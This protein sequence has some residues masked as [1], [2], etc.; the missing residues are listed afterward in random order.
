[1]PI[2]WEDDAYASIGRDG[3]QDV[4]NKQ[5]VRDADILVGFF[6]TRL[7]TAT[8]KAESGSVEEINEFIEAGKPVLLY[9]SDQPVRMEGVDQKQYASLV[10]FRASLQPKGLTFG[11]DN[12]HQLR[13]LLSGHLLRTVRERFPGNPA[14]VDPAKGH[15]KLAAKDA[16]EFLIK[17]P[18]LAW[19]TERDSATH[20]DA[21]GKEVLQRLYESLLSWRATYDTAVEDDVL[22]DIDSAIKNTKAML[23]HKMALDGGV[24]WKAFW[25][26]GDAAFSSLERAAKRLSFEKPEDSLSEQA[27][28]LLHEIDSHPES[29]ERGI[30]VVDGRRLGPG[31]GHYFPYQWNSLHHSGGS[32]D[33]GPL[34]P[35]RKCVAELTTKRYLEKASDDGHFAIYARSG[36]PAPSP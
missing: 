4:I 34:A 18:R 13:E 19:V 28:E 6:W 10:T 5:I 15:A 29:E 30:T 11:Y 20:T 2:K 23:Q 12:M 32:V 1:M 33:V 16:L 36:K 24:S 17:R 8:G 21:E 9:F 22:R 27:T 7:G 3:P 26:G 31:L 25:E 14:Q 35:V